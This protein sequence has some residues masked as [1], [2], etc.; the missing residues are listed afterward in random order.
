M[1]SLFIVPAWIEAH[2]VVPDFEM[3]GTPFLLSGEQADFLV[4]HYE[5]RDDVDGFIAMQFDGAVWRSRGEVFKYRRSQLVRGQKWGKSP[6]VAAVV[7][8]EA[9]GPVL[10]DGRAAGGELYRCADHE[11]PCGWEYEYRPGEAMGRAWD[12]ALIHITATS[13]EQTDN[14]YDALRPMI[15]NGPLSSVIPRT[16]EEVIRLPNGGEIAPVTSKASSRLGARTTFVVQDETGIWTASNGGHALATTQRRSLGGI[17]G[18]SMETT[19]AWDPAM[20]STAQRTFESLA[21]DIYKDFRTPPDDLDF[22]VFDERQQIFEFNYADCPWV[23]I[24][25]IEADANELMEKNPREAERFYGNRVV[26]G[27]GSWM[28]MPAYKARVAPRTARAGSKIVIGFDGSDYEDWTVIRCE[29]LDGF[30]WTPRFKAT[31]KLMIWDP[32]LHDGVIPRAEVLAGI[33]ELFER[34]DVQRMYADPWRWETDIDNLS[35][36]YPGKVFRWATN[37][38]VQMHAALERIRTDVRNPDSAWC[39]DGCPTTETHFRNAVELARRG[40]RYILAK[41]SEKQKIDAAMSSVLAHEAAMDAIAGGALR[42]ETKR[43]N[44]VLI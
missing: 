18:R 30:Q 6:F 10:Y 29:T 27:S 16:G 7:C 35:G 24:A 5:L 32:S 39:H 9:V 12:T 31:G 44:Y 21:E 20:D 1:D 17:R 43:K 2:A 25:N 37:R 11:C 19:N 23:V 41:A 33:H 4:H 42:D 8:A 36:E 34:F 15:D 22:D 28:D 3:K 40:Q 38:D 13:E 14:T 26:A